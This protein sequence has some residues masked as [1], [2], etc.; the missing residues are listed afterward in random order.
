MLNFCIFLYFKKYLQAIVHIRKDQ[1]SNIALK[2]C[3]RTLLLHHNFQAVFAFVIDT[4]SSMAND[5]NYVRQYIEQILIEQTNSGI[6]ATYI[7]GTYAENPSSPKKVSLSF[8]PN[9]LY[10]IVY[11]HKL[12]SKNTE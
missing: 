8:E 5:M 4:S 12:F 7:V 3:S 10:T 1:L 2:H 9:D 6:K 11:E